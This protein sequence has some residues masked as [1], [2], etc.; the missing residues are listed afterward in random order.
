MFINSFIKNF[1]GLA[2]NI[3]LSSRQYYD[4]FLNLDML[5][6]TILTIILLIFL[7]FFGQ[8]FLFASSF[9]ILSFYDIDDYAFQLTVAL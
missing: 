2:K 4:S 3:S 5:Q 9:D 6:K 1:D 8:N 7:L